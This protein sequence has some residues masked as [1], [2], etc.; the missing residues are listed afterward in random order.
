[1]RLWV[2]LGQP[3]PWDSYLALGWPSCT[4]CPVP[5]SQPSCYKRGLLHSGHSLQ[6]AGAGN[7]QPCP[8]PAT[9]N[10]AWLRKAPARRLA[11]TRTSMLPLY[12][13][14]HFICWQQ[15]S[16]HGSTRG[17]GLSVPGS[18][19]QKCFLHSSRETFCVFPCIPSPDSHPSPWP[20]IIK[21]A[22]SWKNSQGAI[23]YDFYFYRN[24][25]LGFPKHTQEDLWIGLLTKNI[26][27]AK[28]KCQW[29]KFF[30]ARSEKQKVAEKIFIS[31]ELNKLTKST[32][33]NSAVSFETT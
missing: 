4:K 13:P 30:D 27:I 5:V 9:W 7:T 8:V 33:N 10:H 15:P 22:A 1:M 3:V 16:S 29:F 32:H 2:Q 25:C 26:T 24:L 31:K 21:Q 6:T 18:P 19:G 23:P 17:V 28:W 20:T 11:L 12:D 14:Q